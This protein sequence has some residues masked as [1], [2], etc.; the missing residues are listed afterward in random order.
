MKNTSVYR[1]QEKSAA[2]I[3]LINMLWCR[4]IWMNLWRHRAETNGTKIFTSAGASSG[5]YLLCSLEFKKK[6][7]WQLNSWLLYSPACVNASIIDAKIDFCYRQEKAAVCMAFTHRLY[8]WAVAVASGWSLEGDS[9]HVE[10]ASWYCVAFPT[11]R[12]LEQLEIL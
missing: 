3:K 1:A 11:N 8:L 5:L 12:Y 4:H 2:T 9:V 10:I 6:S 7:H